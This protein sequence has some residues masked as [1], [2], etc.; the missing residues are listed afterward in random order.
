MLRQKPV[1]T[2]LL[3]VVKAYCCYH[4]VSLIRIKNIRIHTKYRKCTSKW[5]RNKESH[6]GM[7]E[8]LR[9]SLRGDESL[10]L[11]PGIGP[12]R[13][14]HTHPPPHTSNLSGASV[15]LSIVDRIL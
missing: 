4:R 3:K 14:S 7:V 2:I 11:S 9:G 5:K 8:V 10:T 15:Q 12:V 1:W 13:V 6:K